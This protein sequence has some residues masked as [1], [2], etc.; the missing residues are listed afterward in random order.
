MKP[1]KITSGP[2]DSAVGDFDSAFAGAQ[3]R[4]DETYTTP[5]E[6]HAMMEPHASIAVWEGDNLSVWTSN[7]MI[8]WGTAISRRR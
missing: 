8:A 5:D 6:A 3:V 2:P 7:Q 4:L 1:E